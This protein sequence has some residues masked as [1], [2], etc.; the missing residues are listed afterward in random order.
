M[1]PHIKHFAA[2]IQQK[3]TLMH[4]VSGVIR[5]LTVGL[6]NIYCSVC[7]Q[8]NFKHQS[9]SDEVMIKTWWFTFVDHT[10]HA[11]A[12][13]ACETVQTLVKQH[14]LASSW[15]W[16]KLPIFFQSKG[17]VNGGVAFVRRPPR[18]P[19]RLALSHPKKNTNTHTCNSGNKQR[20]SARSSLPSTKSP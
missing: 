16:F 4:Q 13:G 10:A 19:D 3:M 6:P 14:T 15:F 9:T 12:H 11:P 1:S 2:G 8:M 7:Q 17:I 5:P 18:T 20:A